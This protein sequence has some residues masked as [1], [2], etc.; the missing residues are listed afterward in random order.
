MQCSLQP[1]S[2]L[3]T[4]RPQSLGIYW[5]TWW[6][7]ACWCLRV[8]SGEDPASV[9]PTR[10][11]PDHTTPNIVMLSNRPLIFLIFACLLLGSLFYLH[12]PD[13]VLS[14]TVASTMSITHVVLVQ[15]KAD[16][17]SEVIKDVRYQ[18]SQYRILKTLID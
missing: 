15:F 11:V 18:H 6:R 10:Q 7:L 5:P 2:V 16:V 8:Y 12:S 3:C 17:S 14:S 9:T 1:P 4:F 13:S